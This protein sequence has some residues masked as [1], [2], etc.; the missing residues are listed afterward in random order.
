M[1]EEGATSVV[2][3]GL[4]QL[5]FAEGGE[6]QERMDKGALAGCGSL[7][8]GWPPQNQTVR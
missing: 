6:K 7:V 2:N 8:L 4:A 1:M 3:Q 5:H